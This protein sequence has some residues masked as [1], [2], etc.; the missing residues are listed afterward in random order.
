LKD[1]EFFWPNPEVS[2]LPNVSSTK[3]KERKR[4]RKWPPFSEHQPC[5]SL[6]KTEAYNNIAM[7]NTQL[8]L[9]KCYFTVSHLATLY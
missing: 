1:I 5:S 6:T 2:K 7:N 8:F 4:N 9:G 3:R